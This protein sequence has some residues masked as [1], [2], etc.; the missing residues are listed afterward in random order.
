MAFYKWREPFSSMDPGWKENV[1]PETIVE[2]SGWRSTDK[3]VGDMMDAGVRLQA[4]RK[5][6]FDLMRDMADNDE[7]PEV[8][9]R[10]PNV[11]FTDVD[12]AGRR[13]SQDALYRAAERKRAADEKKALEE[14]SKAALDVQEVSKESSE[15]E[16]K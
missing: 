12:D 4:Y 16:K 3:I 2:Q 7:L 1:E 14:A 13:A 10:H 9:L 11:D 5:G 6:Q 15:V 8:L